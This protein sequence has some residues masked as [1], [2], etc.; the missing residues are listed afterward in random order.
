[1][2]VAAMVTL[3]I[4]SCG[5]GEDA[6]KTDADAGMPTEDAAV[7]VTIGAPDSAESSADVA[8]EAASCDASLIQGDSGCLD[9]CSYGNGGCSPNATCAMG[10]SG[11]TCICN[12]GYTGDGVTCASR[13]G[14]N[15][16]GCDPHADC[17]LDSGATCTCRAGYEGDGAACTSVCNVAN[18]GCPLHSKCAN[19]ATGISC[20][21]DV[22]YAHGGAA[23]LPTRDYYTLEVVPTSAPQCDDMTGGTQITLPTFELPSGYARDQGGLTPTDLPFTFSLFGIPHTR[24]QFGMNGFVRLATPKQKP[25]RYMW[26]PTAIP[27]GNPDQA[28]HDIIAAYWTDYAFP[29]GFPASTGRATIETF[30]NPGARHFTIEWRDFFIET[31]PYPSNP[32]KITFQLKLFEGTNAIEIH[33]CSIAPETADPALYNGAGA[34][35]GIDSW[36]GRQSFAYANHVA[37]SVSTTS[38]LRY[39]VVHGPGCS[40][41]TVD[42]NGDGVCET[43]ILKDEAHCGSC[44]T[45]TC[46]Q[47]TAGT[48]TAGTSCTHGKCT[49]EC[50]AG[51]G[52]CN[53]TAS[54][55]CET[56]TNLDTHA[57]G[58][59]HN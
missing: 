1:M 46:A 44:A 27:S 23:C 50:Q 13:C 7:D 56:N 8:I 16:G 42:C 18:G 4:A 34:V 37:N 49:V 53:A 15:N 24:Y 38:F 11:R 43:D 58:I 47:P 26:G 5:G 33:Y 57:C 10:P 41:G 21:C 59:C 2:G 20:E 9:P 22:G 55:G 17:V 6:D 39:E 12:A 52:D 3:G 25:H 36:D 32:G 30:G 51:F 40:A 45:T 14:V 28:P 29:Y 48:N 31:A 54:D 19:T 35:V